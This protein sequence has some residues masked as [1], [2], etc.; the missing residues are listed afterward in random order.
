[1]S[2]NDRVIQCFLGKSGS[3][4]IE[5][6]SSLRCMCGPLSP[7]QHW[8]MWYVDYKFSQMCVQSTLSL[9]T[10]GCVV[11]RPKVL[12]D[13]YLGMTDGVVHCVLGNTVSYDMNTTICLKYILG[14]DGL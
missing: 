2:E 4:S 5:T 8:V 13:V 1:M 9:G 14:N 3:C 11:W 12:S 6:T 10:L 7:R